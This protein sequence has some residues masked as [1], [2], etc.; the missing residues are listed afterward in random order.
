MYDGRMQ[1][2]IPTKIT[3]QEISYDN[4]SMSI[5][6]DADYGLEARMLDDF[7]SNMSMNSKV[8][9]LTEIPLLNLPIRIVSCNSKLLQI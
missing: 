8:S 9:Q 1:Q 7:Q 5:C 4:L 3:L 6:T 2:Y